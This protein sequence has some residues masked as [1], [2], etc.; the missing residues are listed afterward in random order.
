MTINNEDSI[1]DHK[2]TK[3]KKTWVKTEWDEAE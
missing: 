2:L 1:N 3:T